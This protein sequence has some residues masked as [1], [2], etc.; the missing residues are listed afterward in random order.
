MTSDIIMRSQYTIQNEYLEVAIKKKGAELCSVQDPSGFEYMWQAGEVWPRHAP[1]LF[2]V[3]GSLLDHEYEYEGELYEMSH[4]GFARNMDFDMLH[5]SEHSISFVLTHSADT[6]TSYPFQFTFVISYTL[7]DNILEQRFRVVNTDVKSIPV[8]FGA[9]PA[10]N[11]SPIS[12]YKLVFSDHENVKSNRLS[13]PYINDKKINVI[14]ANEISLDAHT[15]DHDAFIFQGLKSKE[16]SLVHNTSN[17]RIT[18]DI[19]AFPYLGIWAKP[20]APFVCLEPWQ[21][22]ADYETHNKRIEDKKG[23]VLIAEGAEIKKSFTM[24]FTT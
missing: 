8:S 19:S 7:I 9:H 11:A 24:T 22:L 23:V 5:Q 4:H 1:N 21:G 14:T 12:E 18:M 17:H 2:P 15:F 6:I 13:G 16:V 10:F 3:I 20:G